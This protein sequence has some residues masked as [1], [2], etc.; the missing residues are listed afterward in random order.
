[1]H[2]RHPQETH[3]RLQA[4]TPDEQIYGIKGSQNLAPRSSSLIRVGNGVAEFK[5]PLMK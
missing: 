4:I 5:Q 1:M 3:T 2:R